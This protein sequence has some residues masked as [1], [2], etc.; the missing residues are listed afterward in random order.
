M[1]WSMHC[2][3][4]Q[5]LT[6]LQRLDV[7]DDFVMVMKVEVMTMMMM[8]NEMN[9]VMPLM[10]YPQAGAPGIGAPCFILTIESGN[11]SESP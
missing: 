6:W 5:R 10:R 8:M 4:L 3:Q 9:W 7:V 2:V 11:S 1:D